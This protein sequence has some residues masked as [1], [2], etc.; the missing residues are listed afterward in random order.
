MKIVYHCYGGSHASPVAAAIHLGRLP[1]T[2]IASREELLKLDLFDQIKPSLQGTLVHVGKDPEG[3]EVFVL[4]ARNNSDILLKT[5]KGVTRII[6]EDPDDYVFVDLRP[7]TNLWM[8]IGGY[9]SRVLGLVSLGR[10]LVSWGVGK[11]YPKISGLVQQT[12]SRLGL[13]RAGGK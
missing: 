5:L 11:A 13:Q 1:S 10:P 6:G 8:N 2:E 3:N 9:T 7:C 4:G 12:R